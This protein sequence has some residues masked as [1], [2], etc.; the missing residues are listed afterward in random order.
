MVHVGFRRPGPLEHLCIEIEPKRIE[1][2]RLLASEDVA[3][4]AKLEVQ[5]LIH[6][7]HSTVTKDPYNAKPTINDLLDRKH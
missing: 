7:S 1:M 6:F 4:S 2:S 5:R 3:R